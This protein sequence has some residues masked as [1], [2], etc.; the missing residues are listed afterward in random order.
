VEKEIAF[1]IALA[2]EKGQVHPLLPVM[3]ATLLVVHLNNSPVM[4]VTTAAAAAAAVHHL[5]RNNNL[6]MEV[7]PRLHRFLTLIQALFTGRTLLNGLLITQHKLKTHK[8]L[9]L[10]H[11]S[12]LLPSVIE[13]LLRRQRRSSLLSNMARMGLKMIE[14]IKR[15]YYNKEE[16]FEKTVV[17]QQII[18]FLSNSS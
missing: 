1:V 13:L 17:K 5:S 9:Q 18:I 10:K 8:R 6:P 3:A 2:L 4:E 11:S 16:K 7:P 14:G 12:S 15:Y